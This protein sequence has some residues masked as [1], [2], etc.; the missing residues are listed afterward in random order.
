MNR[1]LS[2]D[3]EGRYDSTL[4]L[5]RELE[6][7]LNNFNK[8]SRWTEPVR[9]SPSRPLPPR[10]LAAIVLSCL[11]VG[12]CTA[13]LLES[14]HVLDPSTIH[15]TPFATALAAQMS[16]AWSPDGKSIAFF[17]EA[18]DGMA[19]MVQGVDQP[20]ASAVTGAEVRVEA[21]DP[22]VWSNDAQS[23][24]FGGYY[25]GQQGILRVSATAKGEPEMVQPFGHLATVSPDGK[26]LVTLAYDDKSLL[27]LYHSDLPD[28]PTR[29]VYRE[30]PKLGPYSH[31]PRLAFSPDGR[32][33]L[34]VINLEHGDE[35]WLLP[36]PHGRPTKLFGRGT[37]F[38][39]TPQIA[40]LDSRHLVFS[41]E[42]AGSH[43]QL[44]EADTENDEFWRV[45]ALDR[46]ARNPT[47]SPDGAQIA[48]QSSL[49]HGDV[50]AMRLADGTIRTLLGSSRS[51]QMASYSPTAEQV[52]YVTDRR[53]FPEVWI[54]SFAEHH[55]WPLLSPDNVF[56]GGRPA[57]YFMTPVF[58]PD[59]QYVAVVAGAAGE[60]YVYTVR[61]AGGQ[62]GRAT[63]E[64]NSREFGPTWSPGGNELA[65]V[66]SEAS[67]WWLAKV[68]IGSKQPPVNLS[69][70]GNN[71]VPEWSPSGDWIACDNGNG[72][73][74][75]ISPGTR[76]GYR[77]K[78]EGPVAWGKDGKTLYQIRMNSRTL[79]AIDPSTGL[80]RVLQDLEGPLPYSELA[81]GLRASLTSDGRSIV[82]SVNR[83]REEIWIL[84]GLEVPRGWFARLLPYR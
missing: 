32:K 81:P 42:V 7:V 19:L 25:R 9:V 28:A 1:C 63:S 23:I 80:E 70:T 24:Y 10:K 74:K 62:A 44:Y 37:P 71:V 69:Q 27:H 61:T 21:R 50:V 20:T 2:K 75:L 52:V 35:Y 45:S 18:S 6:Q 66:H 77:W 22:P 78:G 15:V 58:S 64:E 38:L 3:P 16:P 49:S 8:L 53:G 14:R 82:Y 43:S 26:T 30:E 12:W 34:L 79:V 39:F 47:V 67:A 83:P 46:P 13:A 48:Y 57:Q 73:F 5:S 68:A 65:F 41:A 72:T 56:I 84:R 17:G 76:T 54:S 51:E 55:D 59:G 40:L 4:D 33:I 31:R 29:E 60:A 11:L 36:W